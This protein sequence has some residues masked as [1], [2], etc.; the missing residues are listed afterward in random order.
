MLNK[1][2]YNTKNINNNNNNNNKSN[3][4]IRDWFN[5]F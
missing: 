1:I 2:K 3:Y 4:K 5:F